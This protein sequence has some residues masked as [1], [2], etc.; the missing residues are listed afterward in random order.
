MPSRPSGSLYRSSQATGWSRWSGICQGSRELAI[1]HAGAGQGTHRVN[2]GGS[3]NN[4]AANCRAANRDRNTPGIRNN[5]LGF[6]PAPAPPAPASAAKPQIGWNRPAS[7]PAPAQAATGKR[8]PV[9][10]GAG[11]WQRIAPSNAPGGAR[12]INQ[13]SSIHSP[14]RSGAHFLICVHPVHLWFQI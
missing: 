11:R 4:N 1:S 8:H 10:P 6:R 12:F 14:A 9:P 5:N 2:R 7:S 3:W 13:S